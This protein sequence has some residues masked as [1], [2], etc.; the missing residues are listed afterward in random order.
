[1]RC[2]K[3]GLLSLILLGLGASGSTAPKRVDISPMALINLS[4]IPDGA[5]SNRFLG[6]AVAADLFLTNRFAIRTT[7]GYVKTTALSGA[8]VFDR[9]FVPDYDPAS[10]DG[11]RHSLRFSI[12]PYLEANLWSAVS[13]YITLTGSFNYV[14]GG[15]STVLSGSGSLVESQSVSRRRLPNNSYYSFSGSAGVK[16]PVSE[17][18]ALFAEVQHQFYS[19]LNYDWQYGE[20]DATR[21]VPYGFDQYPTSL[22]LGVSYRLTFS[23]DNSH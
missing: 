13:P 14:D 11:T 12:A 20:A 21:A 3:A 23:K 17:R 1:M 15:T 22:S 6:G 10:D 8:S 4:E 16:V 19:D 2:V 5:S 18:F 9:Y 7:L